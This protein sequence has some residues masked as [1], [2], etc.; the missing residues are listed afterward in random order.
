MRRRRPD[1]AGGRRRPG[2]RRGGGGRAR[3]PGRAGAPDG[4]PG[5]GDRDVDE[6][7]RQRGQVLPAGSRVRF[8]CC[9]LDGEV[10]F[11]VSDEGRGIPAED[12]ESIFE[13][14]TQVDT[15]DSREKGGTGLGLAICRSIVEQ[16]GG[17]IWAQSIVGHG[18]VFSFV[19][20]GPTPPGE[21]PASADARAGVR[22]AVVSGPRLAREEAV[23]AGL[24]ASESHG[25]RA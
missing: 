6:P 24:G 2:A 25:S 20:P 14:F 9:R 1:R 11:E 4:R 3:R 7:A 22:G 10:L 23:I 16:H 8:S 12:L 15:S 17:R 19:L 21:P 18:A 13:R 5:P